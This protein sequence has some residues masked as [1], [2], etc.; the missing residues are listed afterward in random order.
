[1][2]LQSSLI[3]HEWKFQRRNEGEEQFLQVMAEVGRGR[4]CVAYRGIGRGRGRTTSTK[5]LQSVTNAIN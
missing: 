1:M 2:K 4:G 3:V 5:Q